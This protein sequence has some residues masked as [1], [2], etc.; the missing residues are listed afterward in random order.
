MP[1]NTIENACAK[2]LLHEDKQWR[3]AGDSAALN[4]PTKGRKIFRT[5][6]AKGSRFHPN[7]DSFSLSE[8][9]P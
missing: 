3:E 7:Q 6:E 5:P 1:E 2:S 8:K 4:P 9:S